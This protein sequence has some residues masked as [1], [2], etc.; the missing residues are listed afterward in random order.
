MW[1]KNNYTNELF[2]WDKQNANLK[3]WYLGSQPPF[4]LVFYRNYKLLADEWNLMDLAGLK[5][6]L[7]VPETRKPNE[8]SSAKILHWNGVFKPWM[9]EGY[10]GEIWRQYFPR[11]RTMLPSNHEILYKNVCREVVWT[12]LHRQEDE[13]FTV[14]I[15]SFIR[16]DNVRR[17][18]KNLSNSVK[19]AEIIIVWNNLDAPCPSDLELATCYQQSTNLVH[20]RYH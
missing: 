14:V 19:I 3:L 10:Y 15:L 7:G 1:R 17:I 8:V 9:C 12:D 6:P 2:N 16:V 5:G 4:N 13:K 11:Y 18:V 20:N